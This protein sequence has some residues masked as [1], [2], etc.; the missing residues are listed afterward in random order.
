VRHVPIAELKD[1]LSEIVAAV[2]AGEEF[3]ITRH[4]RDIAKLGATDEVLHAR[5]KAALEDL[6]TGV[7]TI[8]QRA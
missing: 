4:G 2:E 8:A 3:I 1:K 7:M 6:A 5:R